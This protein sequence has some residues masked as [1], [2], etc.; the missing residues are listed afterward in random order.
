MLRSPETGKREIGLSNGLQP[1]RSRVIEPKAWEL[2]GSQE[3][4]VDRAGVDADLIS[5]N[6][7]RFKG[8]VAKDNCGVERPPAVEKGIA[9]GE[10][11]VE[12]ARSQVLPR[13][14]SGV[15]EKVS[16]QPVV[17]QE[18]FEKIPVLGRQEGE[19]AHGSNRV[20]PIALQRRFHPHGPHGTEMLRIAGSGVFQQIVLVVS[21]KKHSIW[22]LLP[23]IKQ[24]LY[25]LPR[26]QTS[27]DVVAKEDDH[28]LPG[29]ERQPFHQRFEFF[30]APVNITNGKD[31]PFQ[32]M[33]PPHCIPSLTHPLFIYNTNP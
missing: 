31:F 26:F 12:S 11:S 27:I 2:H 20:V 10:Q 14:D 1:V 9:N 19:I 23:Q 8:S 3:V 29:I 15:G 17:R 16:F 24:K 25:Y 6:E 33:T 22:R 32:R 28:V 5:R 30:E 18:S 21:E 4:A 7:G 13:D